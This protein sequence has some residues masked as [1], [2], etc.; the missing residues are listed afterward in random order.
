[1]ALG[2]LLNS[3]LIVRNDIVVVS[4]ID[5]VENAVIDR[6]PDLCQINIVLGQTGG[7]RRT[8]RPRHRAHCLAC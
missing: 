5:A 8:V 4:N 2:L 1:M 3:F 7:S 6:N